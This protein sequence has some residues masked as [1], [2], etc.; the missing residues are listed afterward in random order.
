MFRNLSRILLEFIYPLGLASALVILAFIIQRNRWQ[1]GVLLLIFLI[2]FLGGNRWVALNLARPLEWRYVQ[3][4]GDLKADV[5]VVLA[6]GVQ[7][8]I[9]PRHI[10]EV[11]EVGDRL[12]YAVYLYRQGAAPLILHS[13]EGIDSTD[14]PGGNI[15][16]LFKTMG[17]PSEAVILETDSQD[18]YGN[19]IACQKILEEKGFERIILVTS[20]AHMPRSIGVFRHL[21]MDVIPAPTGFTATKGDSGISLHQGLASLMKSLLPNAD[22]LKTTTRMIKEYIGILVYKIRGWL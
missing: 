8:P 17:I 19:A 1:K 2:L 18:T 11:G 22:N 21:G 5:I 13:G 6:S 16:F 7:S 20:A 9:F 10:P 12:I 4:P 14:V 15:P 3:P